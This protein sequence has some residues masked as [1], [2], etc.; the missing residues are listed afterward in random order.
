MTLLPSSNHVD[1]FRSTEY[2]DVS[3]SSVCR[4]ITSVC[5]SHLPVYQVCLS[6]T[7]RRIKLCTQC[8]SKHSWLTQWR[9]S[10][11]N[12]KL[13]VVRHE[14]HGDVW[15]FTSKNRFTSTPN[16]FCSY[17]VL[18]LRSRARRTSKELLTFDWVTSAK[19]EIPSQS[20]QV[21]YSTSLTFIM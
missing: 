16:I 7:K 4:S 11:W 12:K 18:M 20:L 3:T 17:G 21:R 8:F 5:L 19:V 6:W 9:L 10:S 15:F 13:Q 14:R 1:L 2:G